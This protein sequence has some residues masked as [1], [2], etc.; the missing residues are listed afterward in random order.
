M[1]TSSPHPAR[2]A[3]TTVL[4]GAQWAQW[5]LVVAL[6]VATWRLWPASLG[7][8][9]S[10]TGVVGDSMLPTLEHDDLLVIRRHDSYA[11]GDIVVFRIPEGPGT[12]QRIVHRIV[13]GDAGGYELRGDNRT[14]DDQWTPTAAQIDGSEVLRIPGGARL[15]RQ[16]ARVATWPVTWG[17]FVAI[18]VGVVVWVSTR[19]DEAE[20]PE[21]AAEPAS[22]RVGTAESR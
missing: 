2:D 20:P 9:T 3:G 13:G 1:A 14:G 15:L 22:V 8:S 18:V 12:G 4:K 7:G 5:A 16:G 17:L 10:L 21:E 11:V 6:L 19:G